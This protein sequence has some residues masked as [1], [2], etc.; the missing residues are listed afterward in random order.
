MVQKSRGVGNIIHYDFFNEQ[1]KKSKPKE[2]IQ[3]N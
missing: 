3:N 1:K 2:D